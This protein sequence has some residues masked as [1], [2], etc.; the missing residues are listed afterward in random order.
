MGFSISRV[1][2]PQTTLPA[3]VSR[4][5]ASSRTYEELASLWHALYYNTSLLCIQVSYSLFGNINSL[6]R[7][8]SLIP[9]IDLA[10][11]GG[12]D[13]G[14]AVFLQSFDG[15]SNLGDEGVKLCRFA[16]EEVGNLPLLMV[17]RESNG[18]R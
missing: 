13:E 9:N 3:V 15:F 12:G 5:D 10:G 4:P 17:W 7:T 14:G 6:G 11:D 18:L 1:P 16:I 2:L 8:E